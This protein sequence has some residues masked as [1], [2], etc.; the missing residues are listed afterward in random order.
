[1]NE[2]KRPDLPEDLVRALGL[3][4]AERLLELARADADGLVKIL[5]PDRENTCGTCGHFT[6]KPGEGAGSCELR[7]GWSPFRTRR[8]CK[9]Y[10]KKGEA[11]DEA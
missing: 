2:K 5:P 7:P 8:A 6:R 11:S 1:M 4:P 10:Q 9:K 3:V